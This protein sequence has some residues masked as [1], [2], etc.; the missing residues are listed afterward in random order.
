MKKD[1]KIVLM[2][3]AALIALSWGLLELSI[4]LPPL[5]CP[6][7]KDYDLESVLLGTWFLSAFPLAILICGI[8]TG[9]TQE[10]WYRLLLV[11]LAGSAVHLTTLG[12]F[13]GIDCVVDWGWMAVIWAVSAA[14]SMIAAWLVHC[15]GQKK[16]EIP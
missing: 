4:L 15:V 6:S 11:L 3:S 8:W 7:I 5:P 13:I 9:R 10:K 16:R 14:P 1:I 2:L 12:L